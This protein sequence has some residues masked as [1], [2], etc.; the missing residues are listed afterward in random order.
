MRV[1]AGPCVRLALETLLSM[2][3]D[4]VV[5]GVNKGQ[6]VGLTTFYSATVAAAR[7]AAF[8]SIPAV[9]VNLQSG[10]NMDY[11][12]AADFTASLVRELARK[13]YERGTLLNVNVPALTRNRIKGILMTR[14]D[15]RP[16]MELFEKRAARDGQIFY[17]PSYKALDPGPENTDIWAVRT[18][19]ISIT[20]LTLDQTD[21]A[22]LKNLKSLEEVAWK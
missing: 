20:P 18:G 7:E 8:L 15:V 6:N 9:S 21:A 3:P 13:G 4:I 16:T 19:Y 1:F 5:S 2:K 11:T 12:V 17:W 10:E 22:G 14:Q